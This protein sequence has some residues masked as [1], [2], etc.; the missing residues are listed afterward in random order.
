[1]KFDLTRPC[2]DCPFRKD[3]HFNLRPKKWR[4]IVNSLM[5]DQTFVCH[6]TIDYREWDDNGEFVPDDHN[7]HCAGALIMMQRSGHLFDNYLFRLA[8]M[9]GLLDPN[10]LDKECEI[11]TLDEVREHGNKDLEG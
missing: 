2:A 6:K 7:Q 10:A 5:S 1:M 4:E 3:I 11:V 8:C 9:F